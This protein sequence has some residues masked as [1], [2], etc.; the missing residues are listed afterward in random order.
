M[1][2]VSITSP[3]GNRINKERKSV[4]FFQE[5]F[6]LFIKNSFIFLYVSKRGYLI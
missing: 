6:K 2:Y 3:K 1:C 5:L 4:Y